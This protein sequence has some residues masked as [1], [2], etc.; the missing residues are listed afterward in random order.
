MKE[1]LVTP[2]FNI[3]TK[4][5]RDNISF[6]AHQ[7]KLKDLPLN[8]KTY[9]TPHVASNVTIQSHNVGQIQNNLYKLKRVLE[10]TNFVDNLD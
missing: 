4:Y 2:A 7:I 1:C 10:K 3:E 5:Q 9:E 8:S 6:K